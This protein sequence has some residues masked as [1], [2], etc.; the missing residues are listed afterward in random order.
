MMA[1][2]SPEPE[3]ALA[4]AEL[5]RAQLA[6]FARDDAGSAYALT[7]PG[8]RARFRDARTFMEMVREHYAIVCAPREVTFLEVVRVRGRLAQRLLFVGHEGDAAEA[9]YFV[10]RMPDGTFRT[11]GCVLHERPLVSA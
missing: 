4:V 9:L 11:D 8:I 6:A 1:N 3:D 2:A 10:R 5:V 7:S